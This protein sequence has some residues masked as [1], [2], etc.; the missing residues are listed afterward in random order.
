M[1]FFDLDGTLLDHKQA[2][3]LGIKAFHEK[4]KQ[5]FAGEEEYFHKLWCQVSDK[6]FVRY[7][8][9]EITFQQQ[10]IERINEIFHTSGITISDEMAEECFKF[11][12]KMYEKNWKVFD[13]V[14]PC[15]QELSGYRLGIISNG[16]LEQQS[17]KLERLGIKDYF[18]FIFT[19]GDIGVAKPDIRLFEIACSR[20]N[21]IPK[22]CFYIG[23]DLKTDI[24]PCREVGMCGIWLNRKNVQLDFNSRN[25]ISSLKELKSSI[26]LKYI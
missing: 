11:Y 7:L 4:Y 10:R 26:Q 2:E 24:L 23:D 19:A 13:D 21:E 15:L 6:H 12:L 8:K 1:I 14:E 20:V 3:Y 25:V 16:D 18:D 22:D 17:L 5:Y 9:G